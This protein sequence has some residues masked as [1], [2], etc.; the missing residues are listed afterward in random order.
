MNILR[1]KDRDQDEADGI[2]ETEV[3]GETEI[4]SLVRRAAAGDFEAFGELYRVYLDRIYVP[5]P[6]RPR[7]PQ[8]YNMYEAVPTAMR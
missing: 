6:N 5:N 1:H 2:G 4:F 7:D 3:S 8:Y